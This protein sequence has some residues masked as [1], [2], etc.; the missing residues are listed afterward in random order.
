MP[1]KKDPAAVSLGKKG[2]EARRKAL[3][4]AQRSESARH[5]VVERWRRYRAAQKK[6]GQS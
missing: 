4:K 2:G 3:T 5:A 6:A 1:K